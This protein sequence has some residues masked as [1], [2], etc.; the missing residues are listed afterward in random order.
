MKIEHYLIAVMVLGLLAS[1]VAPAETRGA[2]DAAKDRQQA[3]K[4]G[5]ASATEARQRTSQKRNLAHAGPPARSSVSAPSHTTGYALG[6]GVTAAPSVG[7]A[8]PN[9]IGGA[10]RAS[11]TVPT[12]GLLRQNQLAMARLHFTPNAPPRPNAVAGVSGNTV[13]RRHAPVNAV[14]GG[15]AAFDAKKL[16]RRPVCCAYR[17]GG[18]AVSGWQ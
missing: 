13:G 11:A 1:G 4:H 7:T 10:P 15:P 3:A 18:V 5:S 12:A 9:V 8:I 6:R 14:L 2:E 17:V 16:V